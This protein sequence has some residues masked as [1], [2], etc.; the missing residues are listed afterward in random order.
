MCCCGTNTFGSCLSIQLMLPARSSVIGSPNI[1]A[2]RSLSS[3]VAKVE[4]PELISPLGADG[5]SIVV[6]LLLRSRGVRSENREIRFSSAPCSAPL[7]TQICLQFDTHVL[8]RT[9]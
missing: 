4:L 6:I 2:I 1:M 9:Y 7:N 8:V 3:G 5:M